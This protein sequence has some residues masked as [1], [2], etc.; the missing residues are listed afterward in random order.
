MQCF[1]SVFFSSIC[2]PNIWYS[3]ASF[4]YSSPNI[5][6]QELCECLFFVQSMFAVYSTHSISL[7]A[8]TADDLKSRS[9]LRL[10]VQS[11]CSF[12]IRSLTLLCTLVSHQF[13]HSNYLVLVFLLVSSLFGASDGYARSS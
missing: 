13:I 8:V 9:K 7:C 10:L 5:T 6:R 3:V 11:Q 1:K 4:I 2:R 12:R